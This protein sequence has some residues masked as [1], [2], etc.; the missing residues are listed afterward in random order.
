[1][2]PAFGS[3]SAIHDL[4]PTILS[5]LQLIGWEFEE[6]VVSTCESNSIQGS[7]FLSASTRSSSSPGSPDSDTSDASPLL[8]HLTVVLFLYFTLD[9]LLLNCV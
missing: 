5:Q 6:G 1:M 8:S 4:G 3:G 7:S 9:H 2:V